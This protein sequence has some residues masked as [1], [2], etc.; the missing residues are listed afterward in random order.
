MVTMTEK[1]DK[2]DGALLL[3]RMMDVAKEARAQY[4]YSEDEKMMPV[5]IVIGAS[6]DVQVI[7]A[8][9][10]NQ[11]EKWIMM[12]AVSDLARARK[13]SIVGFASDTRWV[14]S[15]RLCKHYNR[16]PLELNKLEDFKKWYLELLRSVNNEIKNLPREVWS[17]AV[18]VTAKGPDIGTMMEMAS[19]IEGPNDTVLFKPGEI[20]KPVNNYEHDLK[21]LPDWWTN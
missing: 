15:T 16:D 17:E 19:Y 12:R 14:D 8:A 2:V 21:L 11:K 9:W 4:K 18:M 20:D 1:F 10:R 5:A 7:G 3:R 6:L 13:A